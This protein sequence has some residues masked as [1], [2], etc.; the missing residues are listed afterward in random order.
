VLRFV[1]KKDIPIFTHI[2]VTRRCNLHCA[3]CRVIER[4]GSRELSLEEW[5]KVMDR[6]SEWGTIILT[7]QGGEGM[8]RPDIYD[9][10]SYASKKFYTTFYT[11]AVLLDEVKINKLI[12]TGIAGIGVSLDSLSAVKEAKMGRGD[13]ATKKVIEF[14]E[15][16]KNIKRKPKITVNTVIT[17][18]NLSEIPDL[19]KFAN[20]HGAFFSVAVLESTPGDRWWFRNYAPFLEIKEKDYP[21]LERVINELIR[22]KKKGYKISNDVNQLKNAVRYIKKEYTPP[23]NAAKLYYSVNEDGRFMGCQDLEPIPK[24][25]DE[26]QSI[27]EAWQYKKMIKDIETCPGCYYGCYVSIT[28]LASNPLKFLI[29][30]ILH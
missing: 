26:M 9:I 6:M 1:L 19:A 24:R 5:K 29:G 12:S 27:K 4:R 11:N 28:D 2:Y 3:K 8:L 25:I 10:L 18:L 22:M 7:V 14:L 17:H 15:Y 21:E 16:V 13:I 20:E 30:E 23:C